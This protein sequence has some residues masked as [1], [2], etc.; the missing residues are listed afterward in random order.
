MVFGLSHLPLPLLHAER[1]SLAAP[2]N[3]YVVFLQ[4]VQK[5]SRKSP[6]WPACPAR[7]AERLLALDLP[8]PR[9]KH[10]SAAGR[11]DGGGREIVEET[12]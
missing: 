4:K 3:L 7:Q 2:D 11:H 1:L 6:Q 12:P 8:L 10:G 5:C 9:E